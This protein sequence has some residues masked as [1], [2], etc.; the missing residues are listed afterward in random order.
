MNCYYGFHC[1]V[2][3]SETWLLSTACF[4]QCFMVHSLHTLYMHTSWQDQLMA[5]MHQFYGAVLLQDDIS[6][7]AATMVTGE[8]DHTPSILV[9]L[10]HTLHCSILSTPHT[11]IH[12][13]PVSSFDCRNGY[14]DKKTTSSSPTAPHIH[15]AYI[16][17][18]TGF[19]LPLYG[20]AVPGPRGVLPSYSRLSL[21]SQWAPPSTQGSK[22]CT[23]VSNSS[24]SINYHIWYVEGFNLIWK[25]LY[26]PNQ[27]CYLGVSCFGAHSL[28]P[29][30][31]GSIPLPS[32]ASHP[33][34]LHAM[35]L[36]QRVLPLGDPCLPTSE[37]VHG[38][39]ERECP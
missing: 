32:V 12:R 25:N 38:V 2:C 3:N 11:L 34:Q 19:P 18:S 15:I 16:N 35:D 33:G 13:L 6:M 8:E 7:T 4:L 14:I 22:L 27:L 1:V 37:G 29:T 10:H 21:L 36:H 17:L 24:H 26:F 31:W 28:W 5:L 9:R 20:S 30:G 23:S 39:C